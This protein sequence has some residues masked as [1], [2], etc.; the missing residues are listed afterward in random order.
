MGELYC[1]V[2]GLSSGD[3]GIL[4]ILLVLL[5][6]SNIAIA[7]LNESMSS[8]SDLISEQTDYDFWVEA[9]GSWL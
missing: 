5:I 6:S 4:L 7:S 3:F 9:S 1:K 8:V 2:G